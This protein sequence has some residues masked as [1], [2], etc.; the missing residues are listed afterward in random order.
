MF[1]APVPYWTTNGPETGSTIEALAFVPSD[2]ECQTYAFGTGNSA[3]SATN[4]GGASWVDIDPQ[5]TVPDRAVT[6]LAFAPNDASTLYVTLSGFGSGHLFRGIGIFSGSPQWTDIGPPI[7]IP[8]NAVAI[9]PILPA[10]IYTG[11][12]LGLWI[13]SD[14][15]ENWRQIGYSELPHVGVTDI[16]FES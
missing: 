9:D 8:H 14:G 10:T 12:D 3:L 16:E 13:T 6:D 11:T 15:G 2:A 5:N 1:T 7:D 4:D